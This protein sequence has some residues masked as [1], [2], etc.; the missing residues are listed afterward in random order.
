MQ[1][2]LATNPE[3]GDATHTTANT[4]SPERVEGYND[5]A[6]SGHVTTSQREVTSRST[7]VLR[8]HDG[9][10]YVLPYL[11]WEV[12]WPTTYMYVTILTVF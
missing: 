5:M 3:D 2:P 6:A 1:A 12:S 9:D 4:T 11:P 7:L 8:T 10:R